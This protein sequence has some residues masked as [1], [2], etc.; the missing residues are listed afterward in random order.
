MSE[1]NVAAT[2]RV[3]VPLVNLPHYPGCGPV[4][5]SGKVDP[6]VRGVSIAAL[7]I[8][9]ERP[10]DNCSHGSFIGLQ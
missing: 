9:R 2:L 8:C 6:P 7:E 3:R 4:N 1:A 5:P 10:V